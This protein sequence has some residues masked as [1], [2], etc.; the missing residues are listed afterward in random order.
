MVAISQL[1][2]LAVSATASVLP[3]DAATIQTDLQTVNSD[4]TTL[5]SKVNA[6]NGGVSNALPI[7]TAE[8]Q[9]ENDLKSANTDAKNSGAVSATDAQS[10][11]D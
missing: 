1:I 4:T 2:L 3:R 9:L 11:I 5:T 7:Q 6:Y 8:N 10:I